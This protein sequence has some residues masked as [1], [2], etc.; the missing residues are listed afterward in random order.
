MLSGWAMAGHRRHERQPLG[1]RE[2]ARRASS[3][4]A[5]RSTRNDWPIR[6]SASSRPPNPQP[7]AAHRAAAGFQVGLPRS[8][9]GVVAAG[10][11]RVDLGDV[12]QVVDGPRR[13]Q[14]AHR[15]LANAGSGCSP[16][17]SR[18]VSSCTSSCKRA[19]LCCAARRTVDQ[20]VERHSAVAFEH[21]EAIERVERPRRAVRHDDLG[22]RNPVGQARQ[23]SGGPRRRVPASRRVSRSPSQLVGQAGQQRHGRRAGVRSSSSA[24]GLVEE[25]RAGCP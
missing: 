8:N 5:D 2:G 22:A 12:V 19:R 13:D 3:T 4:P 21:R 9:V 10:E 18:S 1:R 11:R 23:R 24:T 16:R 17:R 20:G 7:S 6:A 14:L 25:L 15:D